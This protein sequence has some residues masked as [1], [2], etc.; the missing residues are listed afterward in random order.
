MLSCCTNSKCYV[1]ALVANP[2]LLLQCTT[3]AS[4]LL[5]FRNGQCW[6]HLESI[7]VIHNYVCFGCV[8]FVLYSQNLFLKWPMLCHRNCELCRELTIDSGSVVSQSFFAQ[9]HTRLELTLHFPIMFEG[10]Y[11]LWKY[12][13]CCKKHL[14][15]CCL[16]WQSAQLNSHSLQLFISCNC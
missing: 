5:Y 13:N 6:I 12:R 1:V 15:C 10:S 8:F 9:L 7:L 4:R 3:L 2:I 11:A 14:W 16:Q